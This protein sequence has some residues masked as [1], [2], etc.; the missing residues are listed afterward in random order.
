[1]RIPAGPRL[2]PLLATILLACSH[3]DPA[4]SWLPPEDGPLVDGSPAR[5]TYS[6]GTDVWPTFSQD[7]SRLLY[8]YEL[9]T[10]DR[11]R[12]LGILP[13]VGGQRVAEVCS[14]DANPGVRDGFEHGALSAGGVLAFTR[15]SGDIGGPTAS[16]GSLYFAPV[17]ALADAQKVFDLKTVVTGA[18]RR[19][20]YLLD[21]TW[22]SDTELAFVGTQVAYIPP[23][24]FLPEDTIYTGLDLAKVRLDGGT[25][26]VTV[27]ADLGNA[28]ALAF[29]PTLSRFAFLRHDSVFTIAVGGGV[30]AFAFA[31]TPE[32]DTYGHAIRGVA[33]G[34][35]KLF[36]AWTS[37]QNTGSTSWRITH[38]VSEIGAGGA[39]TTLAERQQFFAEGVLTSNEGTW[40]RLSASPDG[41]TLA[42]EGR[43]SPSGD[44]IYLL[45]LE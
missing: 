43:Y 10:P 18:S 13:S 23:G 24:P 15:H 40:Q 22:I 17:D 21:P 30:P 8:A 5:L 6:A 37:T 44:D 12:C 45:E 28:Q 20:D 7:G 39:L 36:I 34:G 27:L 3:S 9:G 42:I 41:T 2:T 14:V 31:L 38:R 16:S 4:G 25:P 11:D 29:D 19:W 33:A 26:E 1:M 35:G 32:V